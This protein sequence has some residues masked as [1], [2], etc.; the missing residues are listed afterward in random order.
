M[1][2]LNVI[3]ARKRNW[4]GSTQDAVDAVASEIEAD[5][6][7]NCGLSFV[8]ESLRRKSVHLPRYD[9]CHLFFVIT[10]NPEMLFRL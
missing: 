10:L 2:L 5:V 1:N 6:S 9:R 8:N 7:Q 4:Q 3:T